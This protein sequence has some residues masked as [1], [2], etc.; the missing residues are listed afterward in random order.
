MCLTGSQYGWSCFPCF[1]PCSILFAIFC[2]LELCSSSY[3]TSTCGS[4]LPLTSLFPTLS[5]SPLPNHHAHYATVFT[6]LSSIACFVFL[7]ELPEL[8]AISSDLSASKSAQRGADSE[9][10]QRSGGGGSRNWDEVQ[11]LNVVVLSTWSEVNGMAVRLSIIYVF[12]VR[13]R[14]CYLNKLYK[15]QLQVLEFAIVKLER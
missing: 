6:A 2:T 5:P 15:P 12:I 9:T 13:S 14:L 8:L 7:A 3:L 1:S 11:R 4:V 10:P